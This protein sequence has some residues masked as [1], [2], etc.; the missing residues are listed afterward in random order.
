MD[1][2]NSPNPQMVVDVNYK[3]RNWWMD[4][5]RDREREIRQLLGGP[6]LEFWDPVRMVFKFVDFDLT[7]MIEEISDFIDLPY[8]ECEMMVPYKPSSREFLK[9]LGMKSNPT[10]PSLNL[11]WIHFDFLYSRF[12][13]DDSYYSFID[14]FECSVEEWET[15]RLNAFAIALLGSLVFPKIRGMIGTRLGYVVRDLGQREGE[16]R[17]TLVPMILAEIMRSLSACVDGRMFFEGCNFFLQLWAIEH[18][19]LRFDAVDIFMGYGNKINNHPRRMIAFT[20]P[21]GFI[22]WQIFLTELESYRIQW[23]LHWLS[24]PHAIVRG[25][26]R[27]FIELIGLKGVQPYIPLRVLRQFGRTQALCTREYYI[28]ILKEVKDREVSGEGYYGLTDERENIWAR[29]T[30]VYHTRSN[31]ALPSLPNENRKGKRKVTNEKV[32]SKTIEKKQP[33]EKLVSSLKKKIK[34]LEEEVSDMRG[35]AKMLLSVDPTLETNIDKS[36]VTSQ[37]TLQDNPP[38][39]HPI[40]HPPPTYPTSQNQPSSIQIPLKNTHISNYPC[41]PQHHAYAS[42]PPYLT[43]RLP[44]PTLQAP[45]YQTPL[46]QVSWYCAPLIPYQFPS[47]QMPP[48]QKPTYPVHNIKTFTQKHICKNVFNVEKRPIKIYTPLTEPIDQFYEKLRLAGHT[49]PISEIRMNIRARWIEPSKVCAYH[50]GMKG[51]TIEECRD[52]KD[53]IQQLID[54]KII[55]LEDFAPKKSQQKTC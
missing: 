5:K 21:V 38:L 31:D 26:D 16:P 30:M 3:L 25:D 23:K 22:D 51:H 7:P 6:L 39:T 47:Y 2:F 8:H 10:L 44:S 1:A 19:Y 37:A 42:R 9:S 17:K 32:M 46:H 12:G 45:Q 53:K 34:E 49:T 27:Y 50:S 4:I 35:W 29:N 20:V 48:Y 52:L 13:R 28:W 55:C 18:F 24:T 54:T 43:S 41:P 33:S 14:G 40:S 15:Y 36:P 11:G